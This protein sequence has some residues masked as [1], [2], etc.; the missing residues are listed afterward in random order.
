[1]A[2]SWLKDYGTITIGALTLGGGLAIFAARSVAAREVAPLIERIGK[3]ET[4]IDAQEKRLD[5][6]ADQVDYLYRQAGGPP[7]QK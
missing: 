6:M 5:R 7:I 2:R 4:Q 3:A 1:M